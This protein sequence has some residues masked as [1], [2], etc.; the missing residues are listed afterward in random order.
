MKK[1]KP[2]QTL[3]D[4]FADVNALI[5]GDVMIDS[6]LWGNVD[7]ISPEA[8]VPIVS[9]SKKENRLGGAANVAI[10]ILSLEA[11]PLLCSVIG[12]DDASRIFFDLMKNEGLSTD[13]IIQA[14]DRP[15]TVK[16]RIIGNNYQM[17]RVDDEVTTEISAKEKKRLL[18]RIKTLIESRKPSVIIFEDYDKGCISK[19]LI[20]QVMKIAS[21]KK[22]PV[23][24]DPKKKNFSTYK[25]ATL[26]KPNLK[27]LRQGMKLDF[28][29]QS[30]SEIET[31]ARKFCI[32]NGHESLMVTLSER[33]LLLV[34]AK[35]AIHIPA[36]K[37]DIADVSGAGD[38]VISVASLCVATNAEEK[39]I[40]A[41]SNIAGGIVCEHSGVV[42]IE[43]SKLIS[44]ASKLIN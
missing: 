43:K 37:R 5:I 36:H 14:D 24:V 32:E 39:N 42:P 1:N 19:W 34:N 33:G 40:A 15:T 2:I 9:I 16:T 26:F 6:Y 22:I 12:N 25:K 13:G 28:S 44:E 10:N 20:E 27:E 17:I 3:I 30:I 7:R 4:K 18:E 21:S 35:D 23:T 11:K 29:S 38:T 31:A 8:P 41:L